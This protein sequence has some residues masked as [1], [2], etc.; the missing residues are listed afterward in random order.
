MSPD[1]QLES[2]FVSLG[3]AETYARAYWAWLKRQGPQ[4][5][6]K[7]Y[8]IADHMAQQVRSRLA[9]SYPP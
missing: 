5:N 6:P 3:K 1:E 9:Q 8:G 2:W 4:P 7:E